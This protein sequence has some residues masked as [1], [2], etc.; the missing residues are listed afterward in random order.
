MAS[1]EELLQVLRHDLHKV[2]ITGALAHKAALP[3]ELARK[4]DGVAAWLGRNFLREPFE[5]TYYRKS[6][7]FRTLNLYNPRALANQ[8]KVE[9][10]ALFTE[11][12]SIKLH[13]AILNSKLLNL[14]SEARTFPYSSLKYHILLTTALY[15][16]FDNGVG[17]NDL[18]LCENCSSESPF[19]IIYNDSIH[20]WALLPQ[21]EGILAKFSPKFHTLWERRQKVSIGGDYKILDALLSLIGSWTV[22]LAFLE[23]FQ[24][25]TALH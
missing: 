12:D 21:K 19:Q 7:V 1:N 3:S 22:A 13:Q 15:Y 2:R 18:N 11:S 24:A 8:N 17:L 16:N 9:V 20:E 5:T 4:A 25:L 23:D 6:L 14:Y 10:A